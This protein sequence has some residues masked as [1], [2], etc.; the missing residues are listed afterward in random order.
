MSYFLDPLD[1]R[2]RGAGRWMTLRPFRYQ[3]DVGDCTVIVPAEFITDLASVPRVPFAYLLTGGRAP[4]PSVIHDFLYQH[5]DWENRE[6]GDAIFAE[7]M[8]VEQPEL[9][10]EGEG[11]VIRGLMWAGVRAGGWYPWNKH[12]GQVLNPVWSTT[13]WP[14]AP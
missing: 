3:S 6:L 5:P 7:A 8:G 14:E 2:L 11:S 9:G 1:L 13:G 12:R 4:G 10:F